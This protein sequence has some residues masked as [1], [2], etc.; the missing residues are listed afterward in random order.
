MRLRELISKS[1]EAN[2][3]AD[4]PFELQEGRTKSG[5]SIY[6]VRAFEVSEGD[7]GW[8]DENGELTDL[9]DEI[10]PLLKDGEILRITHIG[11]H[12]GTVHT[13]NIYLLTWDGRTEYKDLIGIQRHLCEELGV[14]P[15]LAEGFRS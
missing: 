4:L 9:G 8:R 12:K 1:A 7:F 14:D 13:A 15:K 5:N 2:P 11:W 10:Q 6:R 3:V